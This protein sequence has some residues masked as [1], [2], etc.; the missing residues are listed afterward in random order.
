MITIVLVDDHQLVR[1]GVKSLLNLEPDF[2]VIGEASNGIDGIALV[3]RLHP[4]ILLSDLMMGDFGGIDVTRAVCKS[5]PKTKTIILSMYGDP[6]Y[7]KHALKEGARG[8]VLKGNSIDELVAAIRTV[9][10]GECYIS[11][12]ITDQHGGL[13][14]GAIAGVSAIVPRLLP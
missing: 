9:D 13:I 6:V 1:Q 14:V 10:A 4:D 11:Q 3:E 7:I 5:C 12:E 2:K 8:W